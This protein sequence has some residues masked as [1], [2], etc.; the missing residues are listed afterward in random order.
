MGCTVCDELVPSDRVRLL[1]RR[2][3]LLFLQVDCSACGSTSLGFL[4]GD[5]AI[6]VDAAAA[7]PAISSDDV[8]D[9]HALLASW[10]GGLAGLVRV[11]G[12][13]DDRAGDRADRRTR[14]PA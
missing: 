1:A 9:M 5:G 13:A 11:P 10:S 7:G 12:A 6:G 2:D 4:E 8:L 14:P 3:D